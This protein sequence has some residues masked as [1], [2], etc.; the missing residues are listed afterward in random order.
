MKGP[1]PP[2]SEHRT[3]NEALA[4]A[5]A[6]RSCITF[7]DLQEREGSLSFREIHERA[8]RAAAALRAQGI[9]TGDRVALVLP[10]SPAFMDAYFGALLAGAVPV[11]LYP[12]FRLGRLPEYH[13]STARMIGAVEASIVLADSRTRKLLGQAIEWSRPPLGCRTLEDLDPENAGELQDDVEPDA[14]GLIQFSSGSTADPKPVALSHRNLMSQ[15]AVL[16]ALMPP[17]DRFPHSGVSWLPLYHDMGLISCLLLAVY[18]AR[19]LVLVQPEH[20]LARPALWLRAIARH[21]ATLSVAPTFGYEVCTK[22]VRDDDLAGVDLSSWLLAVCGA[23]PVVLDVLERF[24]GRF[25][26]FGFDRRALRPVYGLA[27]ASLAVTFTPPNRDI[28]AIGVDPAHLASTGQAVEGPRAFRSA[29]RFQA[30]RS[31]CAAPTGGPCR[32]AAWGGSSPAA[33]L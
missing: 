21:R 10:T 12:P 16:K 2:T 17:E 23:E 11:P 1:P 8:R 19:P 13:A 18:Y 5:A 25:A 14:L 33:R 28:K 3:V 9:S 32:S 7:V 30:A 6:T 22:R 20:F 31:R 27:E 15:L 29:R 26:A 24:V 4:C